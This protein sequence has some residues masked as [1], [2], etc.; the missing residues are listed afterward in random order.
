MPHWADDSA[1]RIGYWSMQLARDNTFGI[2]GTRTCEHLLEKIASARTPV[3]ED[4]RAD[5]PRDFPLTPPILQVMRLD[6]AQDNSPTMTGA[7][8]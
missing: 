7:T 4:A 3:H 5:L 1:N 6:S 2:P 8:R